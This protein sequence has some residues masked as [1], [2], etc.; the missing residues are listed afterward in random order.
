MRREARLL[1][2][3]LALCALAFPAPRAAAQPF[4][5]GG[6]GG[7]PNLR[8]ISGQPLPDQGMPAGTVSVRVARKI[9]ANG[10]AGVEVAA[11]IKNAGGD[12]RKRTLKTD[13]GGRVLF[14]SLAPGDEFHAEVT[15]DGELLQTLTFPVPPQGGVRTLLIAGLGPAPAGGAEDAQAPGPRE[16]AR[17]FALGSTTGTGRSP[18]KAA[19]R[20]RRS[21]CASSTR[22]DT[23]SPTTP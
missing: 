21:R 16:A 11:I 6:G 12:M 1:L 23:P 4:A 15:V 5:G 22:A 7:M 19:A 14:E 18:D 20:S 8:A 2:T 17:P 3:A 10:V 13:P 9:P